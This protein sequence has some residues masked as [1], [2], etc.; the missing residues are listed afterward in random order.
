[1]SEY[2][3]RAIEDTPIGHAMDCVFL[4]ASKHKALTCEM[5]RKFAQEFAPLPGID[6]RLWGMA[7]RRAAKEGW[8]EPTALHVTA[9]DPAVHRRPVR[10]WKSKINK[11][12]A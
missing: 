2:A 10:V 7:M 8:I 5:V 9:R 12:P 6:N 1:M 3:M 4:F 11:R